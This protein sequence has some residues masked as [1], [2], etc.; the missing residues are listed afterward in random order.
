MQKME[1]AKLTEES[2][3]QT[4]SVESIVYK[5]D[6]KF[7]MEVFKDVD[8]FYYTAVKN[9]NF[10]GGYKDARTAREFNIML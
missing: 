1:K 10:D 8:V 3:V 2:A 6:A 7:P 9:L 5:K 4:F